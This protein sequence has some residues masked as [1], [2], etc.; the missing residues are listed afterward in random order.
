MSRRPVG[1][2][3]SAML[4][5]AA[6]RSRADVGRPGTRAGARRPAV[7]AARARAIRARQDARDSVAALL[8]VQ[9][10]FR[11]AS[12]RRGAPRSERR[13]GRARARRAAA[14]RAFAY[15]VAARIVP[16]SSRSTSYE[17]VLIRAQETSCCR[18]RAR[19]GRSRAALAI[20]VVHGSGA[21]SAGAERAWRTLARARHD[22]RSTTGSRAATRDAAHA[23]ARSEFARP[24][25]RCRTSAFPPRGRLQRHRL[26][27]GR[28]A[29][30]AER[31]WEPPLRLR[32]PRRDGA[33]P[34]SCASRA[35]RA[36]GLWRRGRRAGLAAAELALG[37]AFTDSPCARPHRRS[38][39]ARHR[40]PATTPSHL[41]AI[42][43]P[44]QERA[45]ELGRLIGKA[46]VTKAR[47]TS[48]ALNDDATPSPYPR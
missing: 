15:A 2:A 13:R 38:A 35:V 48:N 11:A 12:R 5:G 37:R 23:L 1:D 22:C 36:G 43:S 28:A 18:R 6:L 7:R 31:D 41:H 17:R 46:R 21:I 29:S 8:E 34:P 33:S 30:T 40:Q 16:P 24:M 42:T 44:C 25:P 14:R 3:S 32:R 4:V 20:D 39:C 26:L 10:R 45:T 47:R 19:R 9:R 27:R